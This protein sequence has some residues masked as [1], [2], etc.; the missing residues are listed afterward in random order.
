[1]KVLFFATAFVALMSCQEKTDNY[2]ESIHESSTM[3]EV[4]DELQFE[5]VWICHHP[6]TDFHNKECVED[7]YPNGCYVPGDS[8]K[9]CWLM[10][11]NDC[12]DSKSEAVIAACL[13][14]GYVR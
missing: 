8:R 4:R 1:M 10:F 6:G 11:E 14:I 12:E 7:R 9:F 13:S 3:T 5:E 2:N